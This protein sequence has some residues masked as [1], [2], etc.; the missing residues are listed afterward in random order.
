MAI[1]GRMVAWRPTKAN[2][3]VVV[4]VDKADGRREKGYQCRHIQPQQPW[5]MLVTTGT[6]VYRVWACFYHCL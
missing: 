6:A 2:L 5:A 1:D 4:E 3:Q